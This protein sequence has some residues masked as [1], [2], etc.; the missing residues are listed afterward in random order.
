MATPRC[1]LCNG[2]FTG[3][4][5]SDFDHMVSHLPAEL[6]GDTTQFREAFDRARA[7]AVQVGAILAGA[8]RAYREGT[9]EDRACGICGHLVWEHI[10]KA[11]CQCC[12]KGH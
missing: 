10:P 1:P 7:G 9:P 5:D 3:N 12:A 2:T 4:A 11:T 6:R 8:T